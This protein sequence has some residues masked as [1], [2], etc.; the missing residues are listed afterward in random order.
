MQLSLEQL[1]Q[2]TNGVVLLES[3]NGRFI[4]HRFT[5]N[6]E[7]HYKQTN[8]LFYALAYATTSVSLDFMTDA[9][10][11]GF[12]YDI[13]KATSRSF[14]YFDVYIDGIM[15]LHLGESDMWINHGTV[16]VNIKE[17]LGVH[18]DNDSKVQHRI[19]VWLPNLVVAQ[20][21]DVYISDGACLK[22]VQ[23]S[24]KLLTYGDSITEGFDAEFSSL[25]YVNRITR[26]FDAEVL[27]QAIGG[28]RFAPDLLDRNLEF[29]PDIIIVAYGTNDWSVCTREQ[30]ES[31]CE[32]FLVALNEI[33]PDIQKYL[34]I[35]IWRVDIDTI[36][37]KYGGSFECVCSY[38]RSRG[39][40]HGYKIIEGINL[41]PHVT[42]FF[43]DNKIHP[44]DMGFAEYANN[45]IKQI[46]IK[47]YVVDN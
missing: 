36:P 14:Y 3:K 7:N 8:K 9:D 26:S 23:K 41:V 21:F 47:N 45:L 43:G 31:R 19:T 40:A 42:K 38:I 13:F 11:F 46:K 24:L 25:S 17:L 30:L 1:K 32:N 35:P 5:E 16:K 34:I 12:S 2:I 10:E 39:I 15:K 33:Y 4:F 37:S 44:N 27:N 22:G 29:S 20:L 18:I 28:E 6:Q